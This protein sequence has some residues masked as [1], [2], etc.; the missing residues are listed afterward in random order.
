[1]AVS[2]CNARSATCIPKRDYEHPSDCDKPLCNMS[3]SRRCLCSGNAN[4][5]DTHKT[6]TGA[7]CFAVVTAC[8]AAAEPESSGKGADWV[9]ESRLGSIRKF[10]GSENASC[11][12][13]P[14]QC[15][16]L[17]SKQL[18]P[19]PQLHF[20][21]SPCQWCTESDSPGPRLGLLQ[22]GNAKD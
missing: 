14:S 22:A 19:Q 12:L 15:Q 1:M 6:C 5:P 20:P 21:V 11:R 2:Y 10:R 13:S 9:F 7:A 18:Q 8:A 17:C 4:H 3:C 16:W